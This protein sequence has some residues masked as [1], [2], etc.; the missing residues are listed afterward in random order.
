MVGARCRLLGD[1]EEPSRLAAFPSP[2]PVA[3]L[4]VARLHA[5]YFKVFGKTIGPL[6]AAKPELQFLNE[7]DEDKAKL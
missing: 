3:A 6:L 1:G 2:R 7:I 4:Q 5:Q